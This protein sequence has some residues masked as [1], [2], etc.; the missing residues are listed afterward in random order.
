MADF[1]ILKDSPTDL[2]NIK[3]A[4][5]LTDRLNEWLVNSQKVKIDQKVI[6]FRLLATMTNA[7]LPTLRAIDVLSKQEKN[8]IMIKL[9]D[10]LRE[11][12][13][14][15][16]PLSECF[17]WYG[18]SFTDAECSIIESGEKT[19]KLNNALLQLADQT[20]KVSG[21]SKKLKGALLY[22]AAI[23]VVMIGVVFVLMTLVV[24]Q[25]ITI[26]GD[27]NKLPPLTQILISVS[28]LFVNYW[29]LMIIVMVGSVIGVAVWRRTP[30]GHYQFDKILLR[31]PV[32][33]KTIQKVVLSKFARVFSNLLS[34]GISIMESLRIVSDAV[35]NEVY[36]QRILLLREDVK[37]G[38]KIWAS[39]EDD[40]LFPEILVQMIKVGEETAKLDTIIL[41]L[42]DFYDEEVDMVI[43]N[44]QKLLEPMIIVTM[45]V[46]VGFIAV[47]IMQPIVN[48]ADTVTNS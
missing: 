12:V 21:I 2:N 25:I 23:I 17:K 19:G 16:K 35:G 38:I 1:F 27:V 22:P 14:G 28:N 13:K 33:G 30:T 4:T 39:L 11:G 42:A 6:L 32:I 43:N 10:A 36:R 41:K 48:M 3:V 8:P 15:G 18:E 24:P 44:I 47:G 31:V 34:S 45:A 20:E 40:P 26:F 5:S 9:L 37:K 7:G 29:W 46:V